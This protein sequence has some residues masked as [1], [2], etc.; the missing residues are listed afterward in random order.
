MQK[1]YLRAKS[2]ETS[3][4]IYRG[5]DAVPILEQ[6]AP[7]NK[8][9]FIHPIL[10]PDGNGVLTENSLPHHPWQHGVY[11]GLND[12]NG[13]GFWE[14]GVHNNPKDGNF[15]PLPLKPAHVELHHAS[16]E[17][18][19]L[20]LD[21]D[22]INMLTELQQWRLEDKGSTYSIDFQW[23]MK[24]EIDLSFGQYEYGGLFLRMPYRQEFGGQAI[25]S[26]GQINNEAEG[27]RARWVACSMPI[28]G[29][30]DQAGLAYMDH[31]NNPEH[32]VPWRVNYQLGI[33]PSRCIAGK[34]QLAK[35]EVQT[36]Q[37]RILVF[38]GST[39][40]IDV[41]VSWQDFAA[42]I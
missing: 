22:G 13:I 10:A 11:I 34:W 40:P 6:H 24:A 14:E 42:K 28:E 35:G 4:R 39:N 16:W 30:T 12:V 27:K 9:P 20:W 7:N 23:S 2:T 41:N 18:E 29:R 32:P 36:S 3:I 5:D 8:R 15:Q 38:C 21:P 19:T 1:P 25:N 37:Y 17:V 33:S 31:P 26:E